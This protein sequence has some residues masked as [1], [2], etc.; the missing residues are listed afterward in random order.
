M[1]GPAWGYRWR[2]GGVEDRLFPDGLPASGWHDSPAKCAPDDDQPTRAELEEM[3]RALG[4]TFRSNTSDAKL[5][6][7]I[8]EAQDG[9]GA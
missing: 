4:V 2:D 9:D 3:A 8:L 6:D 5:R 7:R 1:S